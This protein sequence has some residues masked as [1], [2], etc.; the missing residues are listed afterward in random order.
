MFWN[1]NSLINK[2]L[3]YS[4]KKYGTIYVKDGTLEFICSCIV[5]GTWNLNFDSV[6]NSNGVKGV[7]KRLIR[8]RETKEVPRQPYPHTSSLMSPICSNTG[9]NRLGVTLSNDT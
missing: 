2:L 8:S 6:H 4:Q 5:I 7:W 9:F 1:R 3:M